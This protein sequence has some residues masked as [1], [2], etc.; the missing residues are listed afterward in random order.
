MP[1]KWLWVANPDRCFDQR[2]E[3]YPALWPVNQVPGDWW[4]CDEAT[5]A[6]DQVL[7][8]L[9][10]PVSAVLA[11]IDVQSPAR[12]PRPHEVAEKRWPWVCDYRVS[13]LFDRGVTYKYLTRDNE[14]N[15]WR[16]SSNNLQGTSFPVPLNVWRKL[17]YA[18]RAAWS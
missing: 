7:L 18:S 17:L 14:L 6:G 3:L 1:S 15:E 16:A 2:W 5:A 12:E 13:E 9:T 11:L 10:Q 8:Y 4:S